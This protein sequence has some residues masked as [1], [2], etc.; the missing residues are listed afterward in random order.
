MKRQR[1]RSGSSFSLELN[2]PFVQ[3]TYFAWASC[4]GKP[5]SSP[6]AIELV[7]DSGRCVASEIKI[8][9]IRPSQN[10]SPSTCLANATI[11]CIFTE[12]SKNSRRASYV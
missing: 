11:T 6:E 8:N 3:K 10:T 9:Y 12:E 7:E 4:L 1:L 5:S 2:L